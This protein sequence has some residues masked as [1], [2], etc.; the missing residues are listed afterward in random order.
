MI[1]QAPTIVAVRWIYRQSLGT[2]ETTF[3]FT[4]AEKEIEDIE[5]EDTQEFNMVYNPEE[6]AK[7]MKEIKRLTEK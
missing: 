1:D 3:G 7:Y 5:K 4:M 2:D 6:A